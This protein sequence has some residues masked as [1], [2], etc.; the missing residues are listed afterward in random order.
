[1][2]KR[3]RT[4]D[5]Y[6]AAL[7][8]DQRSA[9]ERL[10]KT[11]KAVVPEATET[12]SYQVPTI[13]YQGRQLVGFGA[14]KDHCTFFIMSTSLMTAF[15]DDLKGHEVGKGSIRFQPDKPLPTDLAGKLVKARIAENAEISKKK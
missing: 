5:D 1:M 12:I 13:R 4:V 6:L 9:L 10:R 3:D 2:A 14:T 11:I 8:D 7:P 15:K